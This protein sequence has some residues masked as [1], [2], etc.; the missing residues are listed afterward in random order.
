MIFNIIRTEATEA[1][2]SVVLIAN[3]VIIYEYIVLNMACLFEMKII[4]L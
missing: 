3:G 4:L 2:D 1:A